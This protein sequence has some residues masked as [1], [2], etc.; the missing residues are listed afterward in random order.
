MLGSVFSAA[1]VGILLGSLL[2]GPL[3]DRYGR[4]SLMVA[5]L[6]VAASVMVATAWAKSVAELLVLRA[7]VGIP[8]GA[9]IP[10]TT[11]MANEWSPRAAR[12]GMVIVMGCGYA[13][14]ASVGG[15]LVSSLLPRF[16]WESVFYAGAAGTCLIGVALIRWLPESLRYL[17][18][19]P[20][21]AHR[22][23]I[24]RI[25]RRFDPARPSEDVPLPIPAVHRGT[26]SSIA[27]LFDMGRAPLTL[28][29]WASSFLNM[30]VL[31]FIAHWLPTL[32]SGAGLPVGQAIR[33]ATL[34]Y[35]S[36][37]IGV[38]AMGALANRLGLWRVGTAVYLGS[39]V[40]V[41][42][43]GAAGIKTFLLPLMISLAGFSVIGMRHSLVGIST[44]LYPA[45]MR[46]SGSSW[47]VGITHIG[48]MLGPVVGGILV[49]W[50]LP[51]PRVFVVMATFSLL[52]CGLFMSLARRA[53]WLEGDE[54]R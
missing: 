30:M 33:T 10:V 27:G 40:A 18:L 38:L 16:G 41:V 3:G 43:V 8:L 20:T 26:G 44:L 17:G 32:L 24:A 45:D 36:G 31:T 13:V 34:Y 4:K 23:R 42:L 35:A 6:L 48:S 25:V 5:S 51:V 52:G 54:P 2:V 7:L 28:L 37:I 21:A 1:S 11:V 12:A 46:S 15:V 29:L 19:H 9:L 49:G 14:G 39:A 22:A 53:G 50:E 47:A